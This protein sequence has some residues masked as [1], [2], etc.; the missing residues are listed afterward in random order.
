MALYMT[1]P[2]LLT[3]KIC[4]VQVSPPFL[5]I[6]LTSF[7]Q[8][9]LELSLEVGFSH[10]KVWHLMKKCLKMNKLPDWF[11]INSPK[12]RNGTGLQRLI[13]TWRYT[14]MKETHFCSEL[15]P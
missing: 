13:T 9:I 4:N 7:P 10:Q 2:L 6:R 1:A 14:A 8:T 3:K 12:F 15:S 5:K 11:L